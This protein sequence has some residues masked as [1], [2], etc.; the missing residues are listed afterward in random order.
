[1]SHAIHFLVEPLREHLENQHKPFTESQ[2]IQIR[3]LI[4]NASLFFDLAATIIREERFEELDNLIYARS[5]ISTELYDLE[6][7]QIK[8]IKENE[9]NTRNSLLFFKAL[10]ETKNLLLHTVNLVK[11]HRDF[12]P[13]VRN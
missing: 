5:K 3:Q 9:V 1:M 4:Q 2:S 12:L 13:A 11:S 8:R 7:D 6:K 10:A